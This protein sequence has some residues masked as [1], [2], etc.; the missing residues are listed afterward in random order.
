MGKLRL[1]IEGSWQLLLQRRADVRHIFRLGRVRYPHCD[2]HQLLRRGL[3]QLGQHCFEPHHPA[4][5]QPAQVDHRL[6][7]RQLLRLLPV[8]RRPA[9]AP[10]QLLRIG[11]G[12]AVVA[13]INNDALHLASS[14]FAVLA[15]SARGYAASASCCTASAAAKLPSPSR[16]VCSVWA[17]C[18]NVST[19]NGE[20]SPTASST[21]KKLSSA[22]WVTSA[23]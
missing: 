20:S 19:A 18:S 2:N 22:L 13:S 14:S 17:V 1:L 16:K 5:I 8:H 6:I 12:G 7:V 11:A 3:F 23:S 4:G 10:C 9:G 15:V 21:V